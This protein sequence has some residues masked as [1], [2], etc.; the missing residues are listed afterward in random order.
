MINIIDTFRNIIGDKYAM[1]KVL[2]LTVPVM[3]CIYSKVLINDGV[4][5]TLSIIFGVVYLAIFFETIRRSCTQEPMLLPSFL[6][7]VRMF[8]TLGMTVLAA[9]PITIVCA[10][11]YIGYVQLLGT[12]CP[13]LNQTPLSMYICNFIFTLL[14]TSLFFSSVTQFLD[15]GKLSDA[16][17]P[18]KVIKALKTFIVD[19]LFFI[20]QDAFF[21][22][23]VIVIPAY[24][25]S[26]L[27]GMN[28]TNFFVILWSSIGGVVNYLM[29]ADYLGQTKKDSE[30]Y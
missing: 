8:L 6:L 21:I 10:G 29:L 27:A 3:M 14:T 25:I 30:V 16:Y 18:I 12:Y 23:I 13:D 7:P 22:A 9:I 15:T 4:F 19:I 20:I 5:S 24:I 1:V 26:V 2:I 28:P 11:L 17:N